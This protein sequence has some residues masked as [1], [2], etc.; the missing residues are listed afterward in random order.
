MCEAASSSG[1]W[2]LRLRLLLIRVGSIVKA[3]SDHHV[4]S[5]GFLKQW[6]EC[7]YSK[8]TSAEVFICCSTYGPVTVPNTLPSWKKTCCIFCE[9]VVANHHQ[10][11]VVTGNTDVETLVIMKP[12]NRSQWLCLSSVRLWVK[13]EGDRNVLNTSTFRFLYRLG[14][15][16]LCVNS[17]IM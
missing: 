1:R 9:K 5:F 16:D 10:A 6:L 14:S 17:W 12:F 13:L 15:S 4:G 8:S 3:G 7:I 11:I 2:L